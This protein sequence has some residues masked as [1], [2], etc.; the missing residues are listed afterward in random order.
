PAINLSC[1]G[2]PAFA[3]GAADAGAAAVISTDTKRSNTAN[4]FMEI[5]MLSYD[6]DLKVNL[7]SSLIRFKVY[8]KI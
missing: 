3:A 2:H 4:F 5:T 8:H 1:A 7:K 6:F